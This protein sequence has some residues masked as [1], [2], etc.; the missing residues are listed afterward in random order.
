MNDSI[1]K[2]NKSIIN[3]MSVEDKYLSGIHA[4]LITDFG[5]G[6]YFLYENR[7][8]LI[9]ARHV[10][11]DN[12][13]SIKQGKYVLKNIFLQPS[14]TD[15]MED[16]KNLPRFFKNSMA[17]Q[18]NKCT[19]LGPINNSKPFEQD[20]AI[21]SLQNPAC[22]DLLEVIK[23]N[24]HI[25]IEFSNIDEVGNIEFGEDIHVI[26]FTPSFIPANISGNG[27]KINN[28]PYLN[29]TE[30]LVAKGIVS[31]SSKH[32]DHFV[33]NISTLYGFSGG[34]II[35]KNKLVGIVHGSIPNSDFT[36]V[37]KLLNIRKYLEDLKKLES[38]QSILAS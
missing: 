34:P 21:I 11:L 20:I 10:L 17:K 4:K 16:S 27:I 36:I 3:L 26:G 1:S 12:E 5:T 28:M 6:T 22:K 19:V 30:P 14:Y 37:N 9:T 13:M 7:E 18:L 25:P 29:L 35:H 33:A 24:N 2:W 23:I 15:F 8:Y 32:L 38:S 31:T